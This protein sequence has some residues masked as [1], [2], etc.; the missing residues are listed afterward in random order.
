MDTDKIKERIAELQQQANQVAT[1]VLTQHPQ[2]QY[3][4]GRIQERSMDLESDAAIDDNNI[5]ATEKST[6]VVKKETRGK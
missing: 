6:I 5:D 2:Y 1:Q 4:A 3:L